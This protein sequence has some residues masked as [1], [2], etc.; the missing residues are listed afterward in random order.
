MLLVLSL[1]SPGWKNGR[2]SPP[3]T[4]ETTR[5]LPHLL[6]FPDGRLVTRR[7][8]PSVLDNGLYQYSGGY[9]R[10]LDRVALIRPP[11]PQQRV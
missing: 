7:S 9:A 11:L 1:A 6:D 2:H 3:A 5:E 10:R 4:L 8:P